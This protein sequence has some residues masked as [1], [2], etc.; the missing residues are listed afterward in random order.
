MRFIASLLHS[1]RVVLQGHAARLMKAT[2]A[3]AAMERN[4]TLR[5]FWCTAVGMAAKLAPGEDGT[6]LCDEVA[7]LSGSRDGQERILASFLAYRLWKT[8]PETARQHATAVLPA[9]YMGRYDMDADIYG[10]SSN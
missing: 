9:A 4:P 5:K 1:R 8:A 10:S 6:R 2:I 3:T 7:T